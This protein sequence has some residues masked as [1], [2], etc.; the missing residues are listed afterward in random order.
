MNNKLKAMWS[1]S[2]VQ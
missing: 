2:A 1:E